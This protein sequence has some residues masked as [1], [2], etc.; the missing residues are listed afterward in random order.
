MREL[1]SLGNRIV[2]C[3]KCPRLI[4]HCRAV[5]ADPPK[6]YRGQTYWVRPLPGFGDP[7]ARIV[8]VG[9]APAANGG[10]RTGRFFTGDRSGDWLYA[11]LHRAGLASQE[12]STSRDDGMTLHH[13]FITAAVRCAPPGNKPTPEEFSNCR[14]FLSREFE[15]MEQTRVYVALGSLAFDALKKVLRERHSDLRFPPFAHGLRI[16]LPDRRHIVCSYHPSQQNTFTG[17]LTRPMFEKIFTSA[18]ELAGLA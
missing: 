2:R 15:L 17:R 13:T 1:E 4:A 3:R 10:N 7:A 11:A 6:R 9:L 14:P 12:A 5:A 8:I 16:Q 18:K